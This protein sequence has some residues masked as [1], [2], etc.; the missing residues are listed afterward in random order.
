MPFQVLEAQARSI[1]ST[2]TGFI[3]EAG[4]T[5]SLTPARNC[6]FGCSYCYV[7]TMRIYGGLKPEDWT[8]LGPV[9]DVQNKCAG[10]AA[11]S[12][13]RRSGDL[14]L[15]AGGSLSAGRRDGAVDAAH[16][17]RT[18]GAPAEVLRR[19]RRAVRSSCGIWRSCVELSRRTTLRVSFSLTTN[20]EDVR[21][22]V[23][24]ALR[25]DRAAAWRRSAS[26]A[27]PVSRLLRRS[28][29]C[30]RAIP[31]SWPALRWRRRTRTLSAIRC[32]FDRMK[33]RGATTRDAAFRICERHGFCG[34]A[35]A[36]LSGRSGGAHRI[37]Q[38]TALGDDS[39]PVRR[40]FDG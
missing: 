10:I 26:C 17:G 21:Q 3:A 33:P 23:R 20:R 32:M 7:P 27:E 35:E 12:I 4:F 29:R 15:A 11:S 14:L 2:T 19:F 39:Q 37:V 34:M 8:A 36:G 9:H 1:L 6:T 18:L 25:N 22:A 40:D 30:C 24:A 13:A 28:R 5:H 31:K 16:P 38:Y